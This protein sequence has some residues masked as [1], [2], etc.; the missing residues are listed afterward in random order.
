[1]EIGFRSVYVLVDRVDE[2]PKTWNNPANSFKMI[3]PLV[4]SLQLL[5]APGIAF[6]FFLWD[7]IEPH[8]TADARLDRVA[9]RTLKWGTSILMDLLR[10][11]L[12]AF[13]DGR[14]RKLDAISESLQLFTLDEVAVMFGNRSPRDVIRLCREIVAAQSRIQADGILLSTQAITE[15]VNDFCEMRVKELFEDRYVNEFR[16]I[17]LHGNQVD[18]TISYLYNDVFKTNTSENATRA[19]IRKWRDDG[20]IAFLGKIP[21]HRANTGRPVNLYGIRDIRLARVMTSGLTTPQFL[22]HKIRMC[23]HCNRFVIRDWDERDTSAICHH[24]RV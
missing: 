7:V 21:N 13:S 1:M 3:E 4:K 5:D 12:N 17:G 18:F 2:S 11:R 10:R 22:S 14:I 15:G 9:H 8:F 6:K 19:K 23:R 16:R 24:W 20:Y